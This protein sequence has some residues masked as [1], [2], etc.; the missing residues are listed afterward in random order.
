MVAR[1]RY[2][3]RVKVVHFGGST[4]DTL[5]AVPVSG[6]PAKQNSSSN[7]M[8]K[9]LEITGNFEI[10][11]ANAGKGIVGIPVLPGTKIPAVKWKRWQ[12]EMPP[13]ELLKE[14]FLGNCNG[15]AIVTTGMV[16]F[17]CEESEK[18]E[19]VLRECG[20]TPHKLKTPRGGIHLGYCKRPGELVNNQV[21]IKGE[22]IDIRTDGGLA[23]IP[24]SWTE[25]GKYCWI[26]DGLRSVAEL[27]AAKIGWTRERRSR[28]HAI[29]TA[30]ADGDHPDGL[31]DRGRKYVDKFAEA[32]SGQNGH[33]TTFIAALKIV[34]F[35]KR[36][37]NLAWQL[38]RY[39][40]A[41]KCIPPW[42]KEENLKHKLDDALLKARL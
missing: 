26:G 21:K 13:Q 27:P 33:T 11:L 16:V 20:D 34:R 40:N 5:R 18:A 24:N 4:V 31:L 23:M 41:T 37:R 7:V 3:G 22:P 36:N 2:S 28:S 42:E 25:H 30:V 38:L 14:W 9:H 1:L 8:T 6:S 17:D 29:E 10:A 32:V 15:I 19:L 35:V 39:Y 12:T